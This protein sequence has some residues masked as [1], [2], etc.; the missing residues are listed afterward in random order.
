MK[1][2]RKHIDKFFE[3]KRL[4]MAGA[5]RNPKKFGYGVFKELQKK[6]Y[7]VLLKKER[8]CMQ[9]RPEMNQV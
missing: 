2:S 1:V 4:A 8:G 5:S 7:E 6:G 3:P 9:P